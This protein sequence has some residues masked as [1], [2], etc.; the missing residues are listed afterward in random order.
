MELT[1]LQKKILEYIDY[2]QMST[3]EI[4][5]A[6]HKTGELDPKLQVLLPGSRVAGIIH[7]IPA[8]NGSN[9][10]VHN[11]IRNTPKDAVVY[12]D[13]VNCD[14]KA[15][16]GDLIAKYIFSY[17][18]A[19]GIVVSGLVRDVQQLIKEN[20]PMWTYGRS[21]IGCINA[22]TGFDEAY[23]NKREQELNGGIIIADDSGVIVIKKD[24]ITQHMLERLEFLGKQEA[25]WSDC[26]NRLRWDTF[27]TICLKKYNNPE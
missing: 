6:M 22:D 11:Y 2:N 5:D 4:A 9:Y 16:I 25:I 27:D 1:S 3:T 23:Y 20:Y 8:F 12:I 21:P 7:Y 10:H 18:Q 26:I 24:Q 15:I 19:Q 13:A 17:R 14:G